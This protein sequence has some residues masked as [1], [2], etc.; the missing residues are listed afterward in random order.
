MARWDEWVSLAFYVVLVQSEER[1]ILVNTGPPADLSALNEMWTG[2]AGDD[3]ARLRVRAD[4]RL[5]GALEAH[6]VRLADVDIVVLTP[7]TACT[8]GGLELFERATIAFSRTGWIDFMAPVRGPDPTSEREGVV[9]AAVLRRLVT[10]WWPRVRLLSDEDE[11]SPGLRIFRA[12]VHATGT[13]ALYIPTGRGLVVYSDAAHVRGNVENLHPIGIAR[14]LDEAYCGL[15]A[16]CARCSFL[17]SRV[18]AGAA[19]RVR[20]GPRRM[21]AIEYTT[22]LES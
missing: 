14:S 6:G 2:Y 8:V 3:R 19:Q 16:H 17:S 4:E 5:P 12:G 1:T 20:R 13:L 7:L 21:T 18:R 22:G 11:L 15:R 10:D 9:P